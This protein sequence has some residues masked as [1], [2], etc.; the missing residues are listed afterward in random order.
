MSRIGQGRSLARA[1]W[2]V[3]RGDPALLL[4]PLA[5]ALATV[6]AALLIFWPVYEAA[7]PP[8]TNGAYIFG[9]VI[10]L[11]AM[12]FISVYFRAAFSIVVWG[13]LEGRAT[14]LA[15]GLR[16]AWVGIGS[17]VGWTLLT[18]TVG[19]LLGAVRA[20]P[21]GSNLIERLV[22]GI[23]GIVWGTLT[24]FV[25]PILAIERVGARE[26]VERSAS[27]MKRRWGESVGGFVSITGGYI[28][29]VLL[30]SAV[31]FTGA[32]IVEAGHV[33]VGA[34][35]CLSGALAL[36]ATALVAV[37]VQ[38]V[39]GVVLYRYASDRGAPPGFNERALQ[40]AARRRSGLFGR[41]R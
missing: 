21:W 33:L 9:S 35:V 13:R 23:L 17:I 38:Q 28:G 36:I 22:A 12:T 20:L 24:F 14:P 3:I 41:L 29:M 16:L 8:A 26:A 2:Q 1:S 25:V 30:V 11:Y 31:I 18:G 7:G 4:L 40:A 10:A 32:A 37:A 15:G 34:V 27:T 39:F 19:V 5:S 6:I